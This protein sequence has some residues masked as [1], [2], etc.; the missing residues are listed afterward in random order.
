MM[1]VISRTCSGNA[2]RPC[3]RYNW[4]KVHFV[5][6]RTCVQSNR[7]PGGNRLLTY[8]LVNLR[9]FAILSRF[10][11]VVQLKYNTTLNK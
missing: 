6:D 4:K 5:G 11:L 3:K 10:Y 9:L 8:A 7:C 2:G 1:V